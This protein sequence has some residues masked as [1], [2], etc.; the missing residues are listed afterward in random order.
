MG[1]VADDGQRQ[2]CRNIVN[3]HLT[4]WLLLHATL[5]YTQP[6]HMHD[7]TLQGVAQHDSTLHNAM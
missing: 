5:S 2:H 7:A 3:Q 6:A 4:W 1:I